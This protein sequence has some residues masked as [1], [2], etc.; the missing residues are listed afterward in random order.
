MFRNNIPLAYVLL[1]GLPLLLLLGVLQSG[2][3]LSPPAADAARQGPASPAPAP[4]NLMKLVL[5]I[6][7]TPENDSREILTQ[8]LMN[9]HQ[10]P[11]GA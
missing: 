6:A 11:N 8:A 1:V 7:V 2:S 10:Q 5:Q 9:R 3:T 4:L